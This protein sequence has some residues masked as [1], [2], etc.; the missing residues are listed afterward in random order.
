MI[1][2]KKIEPLAPTRVRAKMATSKRH[3]RWTNEEDS[4]LIKMVSSSEH[5]NWPEITSNFEGKT[6]QQVTERWSKVVNPNLVKGSWTRQEDETI[7]RFV[8]QYGTKNWT[9]L[10]SLLPGRIGKQCRERWR[11]HL[12]PEINRNP[13]TTEED[14]LLLQLHQQYGNQWVKISALIP[15]RSDNSIKNRWNSSLKKNL[16]VAEATSVTPQSEHQ[17]KIETPSSLSSETTFPVPNLND[18]MIQPQG[19]PISSKEDGTPWLDTPLKSGMD[20]ASPF[21]IGNSLSSPYT[22]SLANS[23]WSPEFLHTPAE[24]NILLSPILQSPMIK[25][26]EVNSL[27]VSTFEELEKGK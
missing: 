26:Q 24:S 5:V 15:G 16:L 20:L 22:K 3:T 1:E 6:V 27:I 17:V 4:L 7:V 25:G 18:T 13:W 8:Q 2:E 14:R 23:V 10:A 19:T 12:D 21:V 9:K 11:N